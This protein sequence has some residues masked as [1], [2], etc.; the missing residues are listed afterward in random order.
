V[1]DRG[2]VAAL[3]AAL[4]PPGTAIAA[5]T[6]TAGD[7]PVLWP[8]EDVPRAVPKRRRELAFGRAC[9]RDALAELGLGATA[10]PIGTGGAPGWPPGITGSITHTD[11]LAAA[12]VLRT[13]AFGAL[14]IDLESLAHAARTP[15]LLATVARP[16]EHVDVPHLAAVVFSAKESVYKCLYPG[17]GRFLDFHDVD[18]VLD[19]AGTFTVARAEGYDARTVRGRWAIA[20]D[21]VAT[22]AT[23]A[24][25]GLLIHTK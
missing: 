12:A 14:G 11:D 8:G 5:R 9:A 20:G 4:V 1:A 16:H 2:A 22:V 3:L 21:L 6:I 7:P 23:V 10:I 25:E 17:T 15:D 13:G 19:P 18:L 24:V